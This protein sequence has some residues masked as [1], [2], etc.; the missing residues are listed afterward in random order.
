VGGKDQVASKQKKIKKIRIQSQTVIDTDAYADIGAN[1]DT[2][3]CTDKRG[4]EKELG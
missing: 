2:D 3:T 4:D 1:T